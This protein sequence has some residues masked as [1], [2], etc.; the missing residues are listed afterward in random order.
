[1][2]ILKGPNTTVYYLTTVLVDYLT[3][4]LVDYAPSSGFFKSVIPCFG[5]CMK[6]TLMLYVYGIT[7]IFKVSK[8]QSGVISFDKTTRF[9]EDLPDNYLNCFRYSYKPSSIF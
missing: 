1:M 4:V 7:I 9:L 3:T 6:P 2:L 5:V 8:I